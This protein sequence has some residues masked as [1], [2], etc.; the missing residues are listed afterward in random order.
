MLELKYPKSNKIFCLYNMRK[1][2]PLAYIGKYV[3]YTV[4]LSVNFHNKSSGTQNIL[5]NLY[6]ENQ[7]LFLVFNTWLIH[8]EGFLLII[9]FRPFSLQDSTFVNVHFWSACHYL[10]SSSFLIWFGNLFAKHFPYELFLAVLT[11]T[12]HVWG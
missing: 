10:I 4:M 1:Y 2:F 6:F 5:C 11:Q 12:N 9:Y 7:C 8:S 3:Y